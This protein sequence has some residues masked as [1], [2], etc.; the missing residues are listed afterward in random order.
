MVW[1]LDAPPRGISLP[2]LLVLFLSPFFLWPFPSSL[3][4]PSFSPPSM[5]ESGSIS[6]GHFIQILHCCRG[7]DFG[8]SLFHWQRFLALFTRFSR[9]LHSTGNSEVLKLEPPCLSYQAKAT[10]QVWRELMRYI[11]FPQITKV[12][13][14]STV[15]TLA[16]DTLLAS[17]KICPSFRFG[18][19]E[20]SMQ[21]Q[22]NILRWNT[23]NARW[24]SH[25]VLE[26]G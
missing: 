19:V 14:A 23:T 22:L 26:H 18:E 1:K 24:R 11:A 21:L 7:N 5:W 12:G 17:A 2:I 20:F 10:E 13:A 16:L 6:S 3:S 8:E 15:G 9:S 25:R 4:A